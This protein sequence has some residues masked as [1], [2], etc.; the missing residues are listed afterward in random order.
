MPSAPAAVPTP[1][2]CLKTK[3]RRH[4]WSIA[5]PR[6]LP[7]LEG[8]APSTSTPSTALCCR[9]CTAIISAAC[10]SSLLDAQF[11]SAPRKAVADRRS[12]R[13][14]Q[15]RLE[16]AMEVFF[17]KSTGSKWKFQ[18]SVQEIAVGVPS[19]VLGHAIVTAEVHASIRRAVDGALRLSDGSQDFRV[20]RRHRMDRR[21]SADRA[22]C[23]PVHLRM[24]RLTP[25]SSPAI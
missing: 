12:A 25:A 23:R 18:W 22:R 13:H 16:A 8:A 24:L 20:L 14:A 17:P 19:D 6:H 3:P 21:T 15:A 1:A 2:S 11:L 5:A 7:A 9:I 10:R 4:C